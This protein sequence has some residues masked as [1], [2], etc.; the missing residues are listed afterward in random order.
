MSTH[1]EGPWDARIDMHMVPVVVAGPITI[2][3]VYLPPVGNAFDNARLI[4]AAPDLLAALERL[5]GAYERLK[6]PGYPQSDPEKQAA[7]AIAKAKG[8]PA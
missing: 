7:A 4:A 6:P 5:L 1:T 2:A 8:E 3:K